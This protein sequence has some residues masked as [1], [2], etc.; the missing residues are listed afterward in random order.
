[1][2]RI[3][4]LAI[5]SIVLVVT[6]L[7]IAHSKAQPKTRIIFDTDIGD[8]IDDAWALGFILAHKQ[9]DLLGVTAAYGNTPA[10]ARIA[11]KMLHLTGRDDVPVSVGR[12]TS[13]FQP[14]YTWAKTSLCARR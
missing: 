3:I 8:D 9:F 4:A 6:G 11:L 13:G 10:R 2:N 1:M 7:L 12:Q 14:Q 5:L